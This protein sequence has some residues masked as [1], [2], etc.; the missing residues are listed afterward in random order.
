M[1][2]IY[3]REKKQVEELL[4]DVVEELLKEIVV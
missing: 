2:K 3:M 1:I 4:K